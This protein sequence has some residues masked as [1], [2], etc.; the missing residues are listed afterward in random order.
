MLRDNYR[1]KKKIVNYLTDLCDVSYENIKRQDSDTN[2][3]IFN[4]YE[5]KKDLVLKVYEL[6]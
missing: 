4:E 1:N 2:S 5:N 6:G 3:V